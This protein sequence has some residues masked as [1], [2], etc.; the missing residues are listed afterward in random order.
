[1]KKYIGA[2][3]VWA[4]PMNRQA[5]NDFRGCKL[6]EDEEGS[7]EGY[8]VEYVNGGQANTTQYAGYVSWLPKDVFENAYNVANTPLDRMRI[9][10]DELLE[11]YNKL[12]IFLGLKNR[13][14]VAGKMQIDFMELQQIQMKDYLTTLSKRIQLMKK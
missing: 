2:K 12:V 8:L 14:E 5:Y 10:H 9:E 3:E 13:E 11:K 4:T 6:P 1:M 7:D